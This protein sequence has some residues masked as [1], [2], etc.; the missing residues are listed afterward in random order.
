MFVDIDGVRWAVC[1]YGGPA[2]DKVN[3]DVMGDAGARD[4]VEWHMYHSPRHHPMN[5]W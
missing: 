4:A 1:G 2:C 3:A 5:L